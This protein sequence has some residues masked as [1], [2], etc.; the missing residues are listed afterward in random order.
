MA[1]R[2]KLL[3]TRAA[4]RESKQERRHLSIGSRIR[5]RIG[6]SGKKEYV[7]IQDP[8]MGTAP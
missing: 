3:R 6:S 1:S 7:M 8:R 5:E 2:S 4:D